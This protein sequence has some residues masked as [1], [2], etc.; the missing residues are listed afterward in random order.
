[1]QVKPKIDQKE[2]EIIKVAA[3]N[4]SSAR[5]AAATGDFYEKVPSILGFKLT[6][7]CNL[8][9][10]HCYEWN[11]DGY[12][13]K[14]DL[15]SKNKDLDYAILEKCMEETREMKSNVYLWGGEPLVYSHINE[16]LKLLSEDKRITA[17]CTNGLLL[18]E[19]AELL[20]PFSDS[21]EL[22]IALDGTEE[23]NDAIRGNQVHKKVTEAMKYYME[24]RRK[25]LFHGKISV[26]TVVTDANIHTLRQH[27]KEMEEIGIDSLILCLP[28]YISE[29]TS[30]KMDDFYQTHF[31]WLAVSEQDLVGSWHAFKFRL[32]T[33][34]IPSLNQIMEEVREKKFNLHIKLQP[35]IGEEQVGCF[36][37]GEDVKETGRR[38]C[39]SIANRM[40]ILPNGKVT[41]CKHFPEFTIGDLHTA[42]IK[43]LWSHEK[44]NRVREVLFKQTMPVCSKCN[45]FYLH[46]YKAKEPLW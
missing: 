3:K 13:N 31:S 30:D 9:C 42:S 29:E 41:T 15:E 7:R 10:A 6:N 16:V 38:M 46:G 4:I 19:K 37:K 36:I 35:D 5:R 18:R 44:M 22:L 8:R 32:A 25:G 11:K 21:L 27:I 17:I 24:L 26:H 12:H 34:N 43:E 28:W 14:M 40:D 2:F 33:E 20:L 45:N 39:L 23:Q 1:M